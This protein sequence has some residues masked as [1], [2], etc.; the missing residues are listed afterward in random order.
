[1]ADSE[2]AS[3]DTPEDAARAGYPEQ[4]V[5]VLGVRV[6]GETARVWMLTND[7]PP[8]EPYESNCIR[9]GGRWRE[10]DGS[11]GFGIDTPEEIL[12]EAARLGWE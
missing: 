1:M 12:S 9:E 11:G 7:A 5:T 3:Y 10:T 2:Q 6:E 4:F 8:F